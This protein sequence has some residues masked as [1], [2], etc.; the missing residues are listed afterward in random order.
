VLLN[1]AGDTIYIQER[2]AE[3]NVVILKYKIIG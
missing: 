3:G 1:A 2:D